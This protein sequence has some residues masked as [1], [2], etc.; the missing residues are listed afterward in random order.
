[1]RLILLLRYKINLYKCEFCLTI[2]LLIIFIIFPLN[3]YED[4][5]N[6]IFKLIIM[7]VAIIK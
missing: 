6:R 2:I 1:M 5:G 3:I 7:S 4:V